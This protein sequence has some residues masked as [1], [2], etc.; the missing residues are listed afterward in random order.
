MATVS[1]DAAL[2]AFSAALGSEKVL[3]A[4]ADVQ[5]FRDPFAFET[6][7]DYTASAVLMPTEVEE[8]QEIARIAQASRSGRTGRDATT[9]TAARRR[10]SRDA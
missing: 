4:D 7:D 5:A 3:T 9:G 1:L 8:V 10:A 6:W 2:D